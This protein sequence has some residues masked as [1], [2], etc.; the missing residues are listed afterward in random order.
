MNLILCGFFEEA[1]LPCKNSGFILNPQQ[2]Q[3]ND[4]TL[5]G[6]ILNSA[7]ESRSTT[8]AAAAAT[9]S[10]AAALETALGYG[11]HSHS[12]PSLSLSHTR[13]L[14]LSLS[15]AGYKLLSL[16]LSHPLRHSPRS[17]QRPEDDSFCGKSR[18]DLRKKVFFLEYLINNNNKYLIRRI[19]RILL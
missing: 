19:I 18:S 6:V 3:R 11:S 2:L 17:R 12:R 4:P 14:S 10:V 1:V 5:S 9:A 15:P 13:C 7:T 8:T 16:S